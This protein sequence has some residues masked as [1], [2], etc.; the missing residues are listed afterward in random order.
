MSY[1]KSRVPLHL[2][3]PGIRKAG[4]QRN[5]SWESFGPHQQHKVEYNYQGQNRP[6]THMMADFRRYPDGKL[7]F[8]WAKNVVLD[9]VH[10]LSYPHALRPIHQAMLT[11]VFPERFR[12]MEPKLADLRTQLSAAEKTKLRDIVEAQLLEEENWNAGGGGGSV[13]GRSKYRDGVP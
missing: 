11:V 13:D 3:N 5:A 12:M 4:P 8:E 10:N 2:Q 7:D 6:N 1:N 9:A